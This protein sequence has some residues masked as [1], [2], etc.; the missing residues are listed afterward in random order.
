MSIQKSIRLVFILLFMHTP[1]HALTIIPDYDG[2]EGEQLDVLKAAVKAWADIF[3]CPEGKC[4]GRTVK[5]NFSKNPDLSSYGYAYTYVTEDGYVDHAD[6]QLNTTSL[7][8][9]WTTSEA[10]AGYVDAM[11]VA[12]HE[13][14]HALG[15]NNVEDSKFAGKLANVET[16]NTFYDMNGDGLFNGNDFDLA[17]QDPSHS[18]D[19]ENI[20]SAVTLT[21]KRFYP[22]QKVARVLADAYGYCIPEPSTILL[23]AL[24]LLGLTGVGRN[25]KTM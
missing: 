21:G 9:G 1:V 24:G 8:G 20:M 11:D 13:I 25:R 22:D 18:Y 12:M 10:V 15:F 6:I 4:D 5:I 19:W 23:L 16:G 7:E 14:G 3:K 2:F 17:D